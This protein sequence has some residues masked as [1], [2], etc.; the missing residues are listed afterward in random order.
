LARAVLIV[1]DEPLVLE[2]TA[3]ILEDLGCDVVTAANAFEA[4]AK[5]AGEP[6]IEILITDINMP[7]MNGYELAERAKQAREDLKVIV[8]SGREADGRG[9]PIVRKPFLREDLS[10]TMERTTGLC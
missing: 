6:R 7:G 5:L 3:A 4:L 9:F 1:D 10:Q 8:V 2:V